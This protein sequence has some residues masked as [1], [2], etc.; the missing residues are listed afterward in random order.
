[1]RTGVERDILPVESSIPQ[2]Q[3]QI[4]FDLERFNRIKEIIV[5]IL[6]VAE[7]V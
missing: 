2:L 5:S 4:S 3:K 1:M 7:R 6:P